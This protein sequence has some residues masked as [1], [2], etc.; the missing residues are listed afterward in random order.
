MIASRK[1]LGRILRETRREAVR[2]NWIFSVRRRRKNERVL[3]KR[4]MMM[5]DHHN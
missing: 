3:E 1:R 4:V 5:E 2:R